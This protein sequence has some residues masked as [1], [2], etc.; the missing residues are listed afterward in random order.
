[1]VFL[2]PLHIKSFCISE[3]TK[4]VIVGTVG[5]G[6]GVSLEVV[7]KSVGQ[8]GSKLLSINS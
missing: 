7:G 2:S 4:S 8:L 5:A 6:E 1:M 3:A